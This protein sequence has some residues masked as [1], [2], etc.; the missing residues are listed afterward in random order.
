MLETSARLLHLL[1]LLQSRRDWQGSELADE[2]RIS[3]RTV[4]RDVDRLR[5]LGYPVNATTGSFGGYRLGAGAELPPLLLDDNEAVA[6]VAALRTNAVTGLEETSLRALLK[7]E[8]VL[9]AR[10]RHRVSALQHVESV[11]RDQAPALDPGLLSTLAAACRD[12]DTIRFDY[13][14]HDGT[15]TRRRVEPHRLVSWGRRWY[16]VAWD[17]DRADWRSFRVDRISPPTP[18]FGPRFTPREFDATT[19][20]AASATSAAWRF[21]ARV[22]VHAPAHAVAAR[23]NAHTGT[24]EAVDESTCVLVTGSDSVETLAV[25]IGL[26]GFDFEVTSPP[27]LVAHVRSLA[28]RYARAVQDSP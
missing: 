25:W 2:L 23:I 8:Q 27:E 21:Q 19:F 18:P 10:L 28:A 24:V 9:P 1:A 16:L 6:V 26:L 15:P 14:S 22:L 13:H 12:S 3:P 20:V 5:E 7:L 4:R 11:P 17:C